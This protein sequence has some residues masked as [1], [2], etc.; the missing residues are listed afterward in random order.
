MP[1]PAAPKVSPALDER[2]ETRL[3]PK[4]RVMIHND[5]VTPM[6]FVVETLCGVFRKSF[7]EAAT[8]MLE[9]HHGQVA[10]VSVLPLEEAE[11]RVDRAHS[12]ARARKFPL[13]FTL[14]PE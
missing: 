5:D 1:A 10:L 12:L 11:F 8:I 4:Y 6:D 7:E 14:E 3:T 9:A 2:A 13:T